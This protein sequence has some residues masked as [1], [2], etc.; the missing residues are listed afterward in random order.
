MTNIQYFLEY[1]FSN[2]LDG[3]PRYLLTCSKVTLR[4]F[5]QIFLTSNEFA[6]WLVGTGHSGKKFILALARCR[7]VEAKCRDETDNALQ[8]SVSEER[9]DLNPKIFLVIK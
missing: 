8:A 7:A 9:R 2:L 3:N 4:T 6:D 5:I 1:S